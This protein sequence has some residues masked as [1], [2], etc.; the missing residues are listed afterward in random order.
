M[1]T[2]CDAQHSEVLCSLTSSDPNERQ[3][4]RPAVLMSWTTVIWSMA[5]AS[6]LTLAGVHFC[7]W[8]YQR[9]SW[10]SLLF[11]ISAVAAAVIAMQE[12][13]LMHAQTPAGYGETLRWMHVSVA[14]III[15]LVWFIRWH[16]RTGRLWF[17]WLIT[18]LRGLILIAGH[19]R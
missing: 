17:A 2:R 15:T 12:L 16:L 9:H 1:A 18:G 5:A 13:A 19:S 3:L 6:C 11:S 10:G 7:V 8:L 4:V 14:T